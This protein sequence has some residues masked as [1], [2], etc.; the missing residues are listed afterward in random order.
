MKTA[1]YQLIRLCGERD[2]PATEHIEFFKKLS[3]F[4]LEAE[5]ESYAEQIIAY[6]DKNYP[7]MPMEQFLQET[8]ETPDWKR[9]RSRLR[10][11][12]EDVPSMITDAVRLGMH[13]IVKA[14]A[15]HCFFDNEE[16]QKECLSLA[17]DEA[18]RQALICPISIHQRAEYMKYP[19]AC[20]YNQISHKGDL[21]TLH[22]QLIAIPQSL[23]RELWQ[24]FLK[25]YVHTTEQELHQFMTGRTN[26]PSSFK[27]QIIVS[28]YN[29][30]LFCLGYERTDSGFVQKPIPEYW[31]T[32]EEEQ[33]RAN[34][35]ERIHAGLTGLSVLMP[36]LGWTVIRNRVCNYLGCTGYEYLE[37]AHRSEKTRFR[38]LEKA[39]C[40][41][42]RPNRSK[43]K[44]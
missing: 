20:Y 21:K 16:F 44:S 26:K 3:S 6:V 11:Y 23:Q 19:F 40:M 13:H 22:C 36:Q 7:F 30:F 15:P 12:W 14:A 4:D 41:R 33:T 1:R 10:Y 29:Y 43:Q 8:E 24:T 42:K 39:R 38:Q 35:A 28:R 34:D 9:F 37:S 18:T 17:P 2:V 5:R 31:L 25:H 27:Q 32:S